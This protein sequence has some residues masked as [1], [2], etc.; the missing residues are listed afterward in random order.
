M[1]FIKTLLICNLHLGRDNVEVLV[2]DVVSKSA[3]GHVIGNI[4]KDKKL[5]VS[6]EYYGILIAKSSYKWDYFPTA[7]NG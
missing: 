1:P 4:Y 3:K 2:Y 7:F 5:L 6:R